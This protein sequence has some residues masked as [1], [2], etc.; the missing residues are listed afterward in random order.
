MNF[1]NNA[2]KFTF[3]GHI[4]IRAKRLLE[5]TSGFISVSDIGIGVNEEN[6]KLF[7]A[8]AKADLG[9]RNAYK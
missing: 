8:F 7:N 3:Q 6:Q 4:I 9:K 2:L 5:K 1:P